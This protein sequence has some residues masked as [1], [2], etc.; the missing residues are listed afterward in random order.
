MAFYSTHVYTFVL[1]LND[2]GSYVKKY[3][4]DK[5]KRTRKSARNHLLCPPVMEFITY[6]HY[7]YISC[8][9]YVLSV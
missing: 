8:K 9:T 7:M 6:L 2:E 1:E 5:L 3:R 4:L